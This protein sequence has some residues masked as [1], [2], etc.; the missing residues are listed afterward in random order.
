MAQ[1]DLQWQIPS[2]ER[3]ESIQTGKVVEIFQQLHINI[4]TDTLAH[5]EKS[6][7]NNPALLETIQ[8]DAWAVQKNP[9]ERSRF[10]LLYLK[11]YWQGVTI[12]WESYTF[13]QIAA[14]PSEKQVAL[15]EA[16][17]N[18]MQKI[19]L[20][21]YLNEMAN[22]RIEGKAKIEQ[23][24]NQR[25]ERKEEASNQQAE[26]LNTFNAEA[27]KLMDSE[28]IRFLSDELQKIQ[29]S[30][31]SS[32]IVQDLIKQWATVTDI[33]SGKYNSIIESHIIV[34]N[35]AKLTPQDPEKAKNFAQVVR[36]MR[37]TMGVPVNKEK[38]GEFLKS[39]VLGENRE[40]VGSAMY[41]LEKSGKYDRM[42]WDENTRI[43]TFHTKDGSQTE[44]DTVSVPPRLT[45][46]RNGL[47]ITY[48]KQPDN[49][50]LETVQQ[51]V[52]TARSSL[53]KAQTD[54]QGKLRN[55]GLYD[56]NLEKYSTEQLEKA[57]AGSEFE[58]YEQ[59][60][61]MAITT[62]EQ[63]SLQT[64][65]QDKRRH[66][67]GMLSKVGYQYLEY[68]LAEKIEIGETGLSDIREETVAQKD[69]KAK[70][71][72]LKNIQ[73]GSELST[74]LEE[75]KKLEAAEK[76]LASIKTPGVEEF[77]RDT[78]T[79]LSTLISLGYDKLGQE[80]L[81]KLMA[82]LRA[83]NESKGIWKDAKFDIN[84][85]FER[86]QQLNELRSIVDSLSYYS[87]KNRHETMQGIRTAIE[88]N[89]AFR[90][91]WYSPDA[92]AAWLRKQEQKESEKTEKNSAK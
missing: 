70:L 1:E 45:K 75:R 43:V 50:E 23:A 5:I 91:V 69:W 86:E 47:S 40:A 38:I 53:A 71:S 36:Q 57:F 10:E 16:I 37:E 35:E 90:N 89:E 58:Q 11:G 68:I 26:T 49:P 82:G 67:E 60:L 78:D 30:P 28:G 41:A 18:P 27:K 20:T 25:I 48:E 15:L 52:K 31:E 44:I 46:S 59:K 32:P 12:W 88:K 39:K 81:D 42:T 29:S 24:A 14:L 34:D 64:E 74:Y 19:K 56:M 6:I 72:G 55:A 7:R 62:A 17:T 4:D 80:N 63:L 92:L 13:A 65:I 3:T 51:S 79:T 33:Q 87:G 2:V 21:G 61:D 73:S 9:N 22:Q 83:K 84:N 66:A 77:D 8:T 76:K 54:A 85:S